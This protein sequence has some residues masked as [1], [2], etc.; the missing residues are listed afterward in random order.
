[1]SVIY[2]RRGAFSRGHDS[3]FG[4]DERGISRRKLRFCAAGQCF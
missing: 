2:I 3:P 4:A 1:M